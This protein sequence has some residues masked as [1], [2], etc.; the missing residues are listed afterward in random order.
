[1]IP[2]P[3][4]DDWGLSYNKD[5]LISVSFTIQ[6]QNF[7]LYRRFN[8]IRLTKSNVAPLYEFNI[9]LTYRIILVLFLTH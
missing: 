3:G 7:Y 1:M 4:V 6:I 9:F 5:D 8:K 2:I